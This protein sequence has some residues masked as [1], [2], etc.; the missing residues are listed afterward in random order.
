MVENDVDLQTA[1]DI[2]TE[3]IENRVS[4]YVS[5]KKRLPSFGS[6]IDKAVAVYHRALENFV[7]GT[8]VWYYVCPSEYLFPCLQ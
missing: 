3:M 8:I 1:I 2:L 5:L 7:Q 6:E 4:D